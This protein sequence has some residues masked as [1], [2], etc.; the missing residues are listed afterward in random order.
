MT[1]KRSI[2]L[3]AIIVGVFGLIVTAIQPGDQLLLTQVSAAM[4][5]IALL[6]LDITIN[7][8]IRW[9]WRKG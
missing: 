3:T 8:A 7:R 6:E 9:I 2:C 1:T 4:I 5:G